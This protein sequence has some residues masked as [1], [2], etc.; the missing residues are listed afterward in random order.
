MESVFTQIFNLAT[1]LETISE[2]IQKNKPF[3]TIDKFPLAK[4]VADLGPSA[5][6]LT[7]KKQNRIENTKKSRKFCKILKK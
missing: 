4:H 3:P 7:N 1:E 2:F 5:K 6:K